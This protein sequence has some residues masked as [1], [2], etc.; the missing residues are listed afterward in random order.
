MFSDA[1]YTESPG[2][3][4]TAAEIRNKE[5]LFFF[6]H[7][8][9]TELTSDGSGLKTV[10]F[11][12]VAATTI[13]E[14]ITTAWYMISGKRRNARSRVVLVAMIGFAIR[15]AFLFFLGVIFETF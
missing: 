3:P 12:L 15:G 9:T 8:G 7:L 2:A 4:C 5:E 14:M 11:G 10:S 13:L 1:E 6:N